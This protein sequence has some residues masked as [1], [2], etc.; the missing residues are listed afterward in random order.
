MPKKTQLMLDVKKL[1]TSKAI[2][3]YHLEILQKYLKQIV[4]DHEAKLIKCKT[5]G[6]PFP[7]FFHHDCRGVKVDCKNKGSM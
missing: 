3:T 1:L 2:E 6:H 4:Q 5:C 7:R